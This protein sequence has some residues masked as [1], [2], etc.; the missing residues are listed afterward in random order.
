MRGDRS[1]QV[2]FL[3]FSENQIYRYPNLLETGSLDAMKGQ[4]VQHSTYP[5][6][7][8]VPYIPQPDYT[9]L[10]ARRSLISTRHK[11]SSPGSI[12]NPE[13]IKSSSEFRAHDWNTALMKQLS[14]EAQKRQNELVTISL[15]QISHQLAFG[16]VWRW[17][18]T[19]PHVQL[20]CR[21]DVC[22]I[23]ETFL[24]CDNRCVKR[25]MLSWIGSSRKSTCT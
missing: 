15:C 3:I 14:L 22:L 9:P 8:E 10:P 25:P 23:V 4:R 6:Q 24:F 18:R 19:T 17:C 5:Q 16:R 7:L 21:H 13:A 1:G 2:H 12:R 20:W 11:A